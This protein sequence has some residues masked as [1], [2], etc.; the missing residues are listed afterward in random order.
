MSDDNAMAVEGQLEQAQ[1]TA[2][3]EQTNQPGQ[4]ED[5]R[6]E[7]MPTSE[8]KRSDADLE[9]P[10]EVSERTRQQ[11][12]KLKEENR[13][14]KSQVG[15]SQYGKSVFDSFRQPQVPQPVP[16]AENFQFLNQKQVDTIAD[17]FVDSDGNVDINGLNKALHDADVRAKK[18]E[19]RVMSVEDRLMRLEET[20]QA[21]EAHAAH[22]ELDPSSSNFD[23]SFFELVRDRALRNMYEGKQEELIDI[24]ST[25]KKMYNKVDTT[26]AKQEAVKQ[27]QESLAK[28]SSGAPV[29]S[30]KGAERQ[31]TGTLD[32]LRQRTRGGDISAIKA[33][34]KAL[35]Y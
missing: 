8:E 26:K 9:L 29:E 18:A 25:I 31:T 27:Y 23:P 28:K 14:L 5:T 24:A 7:A 34:L 1:P 32:E 13:K 19:E 20:R 4:G 6:T 10:A 17:Q 21:R 2:G 12:E 35:G 16:A 22:P 30:G 33:R 3:D 15:G 11:F